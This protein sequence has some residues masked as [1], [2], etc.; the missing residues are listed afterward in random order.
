MYKIISVILC[1][2]VAWAYPLVLVIKK[3]RELRKLDYFYIMLIQISFIILEI[4]KPQA[5]LLYVAAILIIN[6]I[7]LILL[8]KKSNTI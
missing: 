2:I 4:A 3:K 5:I 1:V 6:M 7:I 8:K